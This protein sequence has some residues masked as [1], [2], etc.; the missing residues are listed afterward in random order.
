MLASLDRTY[1][2]IPADYPHFRD[3]LATYVRSSAGS[4]FR[5]YPGAARTPRRAACHQA[6][7]GLWA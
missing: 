4:E 7:P 5:R 6:T 2:F 1:F 3:A